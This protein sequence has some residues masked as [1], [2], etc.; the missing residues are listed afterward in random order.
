MIDVN[1]EELIRIREVP[2]LL[3][4]R[5]G[6]RKI[7]LSAVYR[8]ISRG[9]GGTRL[10]SIK[11]GGST[12]TTREALQRFGERLSGNDAS[13]PS[14]TPMSRRKAVARAR[15]EVDNVLGDRTAGFGK[16]G[17]RGESDVAE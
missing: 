17:L 7:H 9:V 6:G 2:N 12:Y 8:W 5:P 1:N 16:E 3:P 10:E 4:R 15:A 11:L 14:A 13:T